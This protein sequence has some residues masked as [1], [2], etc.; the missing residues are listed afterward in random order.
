MAGLRALAE[1]EAEARALAESNRIAKR[2]NARVEADR[3]RVALMT[4]LRQ[5][6]DRVEAIIASKAQRRR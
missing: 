4:S 2:Q 6:E 5:K 3:D 1:L